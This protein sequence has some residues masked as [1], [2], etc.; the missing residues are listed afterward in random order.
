MKAVAIAHGA[1]AVFAE[2]L[3]AVLGVSPMCL[4]AETGMELVARGLATVCGDGHAPVDDVVRVFAAWQSAFRGDE[5]DFSVCSAMLDEWSADV[6]A[7]L[8]GKRE[9]METLRRELRARGVAAFG[10]LEAA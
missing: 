5:P 2:T 6:L 8:L 10:L 1:S 7:K 4:D 9:V 3:D